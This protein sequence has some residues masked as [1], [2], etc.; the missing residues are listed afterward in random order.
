MDSLSSG[1]TRALRFDQR[2]ELCPQALRA[3]RGQIVLRAGGKNG[4]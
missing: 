3:V 4:T 1:E 2:V